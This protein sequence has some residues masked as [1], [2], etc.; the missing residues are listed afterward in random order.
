MSTLEDVANNIASRYG[1]DEALSKTK[2]RERE[3]RERALEE[4]ESVELEPSF[5]F[6]VVEFDPAFFN[7]P[8][9]PPERLRPSE[10]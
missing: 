4:E 7:V 3:R 2:R 8:A 9:T 5:P 10:D 6:T 1:N